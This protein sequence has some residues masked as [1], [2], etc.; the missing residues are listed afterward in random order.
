MTSITDISTPEENEIMSNMHSICVKKDLEKAKDLCRT[1]PFS[2]NSLLV[3]ASSNAPVIVDMILKDFAF[4]LNS[5]T[6]AYILHKASKGEKTQIADRLFDVLGDETLK[7]VCAKMFDTACKIN[8][9]NDLRYLLEKRRHWFSIEDLS[10]T[11]SY[12]RNIKNIVNMMYEAFGDD[13]LKRYPSWA[14]VVQAKAQPQTSWTGCV[15][16]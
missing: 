2:C 8:I 7:P 3:I 10:F 11:E 9:E 1:L 13:L 15:L 6:I 5:N 16:L 12:T 14:S 4:E